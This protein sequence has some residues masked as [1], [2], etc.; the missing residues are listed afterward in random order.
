MLVDCRTLQRREN[1]LARLFVIFGGF[2]VLVLTA[3][4]VGPYFVDWTSYR[5][6]FEREA[7]RILGREVKVAGDASARI[8]P[9]P[10]LTFTDVRVAGTDGE[11]ALTAEEFSM[12][13]ELAP[14]LRG[15]LLIFDMRLE[16]PKAVIRIGNDGAVDW[17]VRPDTRF[18][19]GHVSI[20]KLTVT[21]G[22][23]RIEHAASGRTHQLTEINTDMTATTLAGPWRIIGSMRLDG[24]LTQFDLSTG[25]V[26]EAGEMRLRVRAKPQRYPFSIETDG[27]AR[28]DRGAPKYEAGFK[29]SAYD[30]EPSLRG[31]DGATFAL[32]DPADATKGPPDYRMSGKLEF[33]H[34][35][36]A[37]SEFIFET[38]P[39]EDPY[40][41]EGKADLD[42]G[43]EP[44]FA[45]EATGAQFRFD[46]RIGDDAKGSL[47]LER[48]IAAI[49]SFVAAL[50]KPSIPGSVEV[51]LPAVVAGDTTFRDVRLSAEPAQGGWMLKDFAVSMPG[52]TTLEADGFVAT[53]EEDASFSGNMLLA[54][55]QPSGF[56]S[57]LS[58]DVD[59]AIRRL[60]RAG[61][62]AKVDLASGRQ[63]FDDL[64]LQ[65]G[66]ARF[67]GRLDSVTPDDARPSLLLSLDGGELDVE[68]LAAFASL[69][70]TDAGQARVEGRD[71]D[72]KVS[73]GPVSAGGLTAGRLETALRLKDGRLDID[74]LTLTDVSGANLSATGAIDGFPA[75]PSGS[76]DA[77]IVAD[78]LGPLAA[79]LGER[80]PGNR[81]AAA[82]ARRL[83]GLSE[84][85]RDARIN[86]VATATQ[87]KGEPHYAL[88]AGGTMGGGDFTLAYTAT[89][90]PFAPD[91]IDVDLTAENKDG[92]ALLALYGLPTLPLVDAGP[93]TTELTLKGVPD[94]GLE[95]HGKLTGD[96]ATAA[97]DGTVT[98]QPEGMTAQGKVRIEGA[99]LEPW[100]GAAGVT[101]PGMGLGMPAELG[102]DL[103]LSLDD[104]KIGN[105]DGSIGEVAL[106]GDLTATLVKGLP[107]LAGTIATDFLP[108]DSALALVLGEGTLQGDGTAWASTAFP[109]RVT[110]AF[111]A[112]LDLKAGAVGWGVETIATDA[113]TRARLTSEG[114]SASNLSAE[115]DDGRITGLFEVKN[116]DGTG[117]MTGQATLSGFDVSR[118]PGADALSGKANLSANLN[119]SGKSVEA[120]VAALSGTGTAALSDVTVRGINPAAM[121][122]LI[123]EADRIG[124]DIKEETVAAFAPSIAGEGEFAGGNADLSFTIAGGVLRSSPLTLASKGTTLTAELRADLPEWRIAASGEVA[125]D[126]GSEA[127]VGSQPSL[128]FSLEGAPG[129]AAL[130]FDA[131]PMAQFLT[132]RALE[133]EQ[134][135]VEAM[136]AALLEKQRLRREV[137]YY[138]MLQ[139]A[140][141]DAEAE[142]LRLEEEARAKAEQEARLKAEAEAKAKAEEDA[143]LKAEEEAKAKADAEA[144]ARAEEEARRKAEE[145][146]KAKAVADEAARARA[147]E[148]RRI[149]LEEDAK[150]KAAQDAQ[151]AAEA[152]AREKAAV[153]AQGE[154]VAPQ[155][156][157]E[158]LVDMAGRPPQ[159]G[160]VKRHPAPVAT[161]RKPP[162]P[163]GFSL[164]RLFRSLGGGGG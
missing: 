134:A 99:D 43:G 159:A 110:A 153:P 11:P 66:D 124:R 16:R 15:E 155:T 37:A 14:F 78:D 10:S 117:V 161:E 104:L 70:V 72:L 147:E 113:A 59:D 123:A 80:Y 82:L 90:S 12:D 111:T 149:R 137:R 156:S 118:L 48:R 139:Q 141:A 140:R 143:R 34:R 1:T 77:A 69:F 142:R 44:R 119:T 8:L 92:A 150:L 132:Q 30:E 100:L 96:T 133:I 6:D 148:E 53:T 5:G 91:T 61:F 22:S 4:L 19:P 57:W 154:P 73:A 86:L 128:N 56:A 135:R 52:R 79:V 164:E 126:P 46:D 127:L 131:L 105:L 125:Y 20:E 152:A 162:Q 106:S 17:A 9:F 21:E 103:A 27:T 108:L 114:L 151:A 58:K 31:S 24:A 45:I 29:L 93:A 55:G 65:L 136:Q 67:A 145:E 32:N 13:A 97:F 95:T 50:P 89:G 38:G 157:A 33:D 64:K 40:T 18:D 26:D 102:A 7:S 74:K 146:A 144:K 62:S 112:D 122:A 84:L 47:T 41:A 68:G 49:K 130:A 60:S 51:N 109:P 63:V 83:S 120:M 116:N 94:K 23:V 107:H 158:P 3:A 163:E 98:V 28:L 81:V 160:E 75:Q 138:A 71:L 42:L 85:G 88:S 25:R 2:V 87:A 54:V 35:R 101:L 129:E 115:I 76:L 39:L 36:L 121:P